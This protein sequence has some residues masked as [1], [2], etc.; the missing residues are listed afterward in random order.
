MAYINSLLTVKEIESQTNSLLQGVP[1]ALLRTFGKGLHLSGLKNAVSYSD[2]IRDS[3]KRNLES[4]KLYE[5]IERCAGVFIMYDVDRNGLVD[6]KELK[7]MLND[8]YGCAIEQDKID[9]WERCTTFMHSTC[10]TLTEFLRGVEYLNP[11]SNAL[12]NR[13]PEANSSSSILKRL[14]D[15]FLVL[16]IKREETK[17]VDFQSVPDV[18]PLENTIWN[19]PRCDLLIAHVRQYLGALRDARKNGTDGMKP[20][21]RLHALPLAK[22]LVASKSAPQLNPPHSQ[23]VQ[24]IKLLRSIENDKEVSYFLFMSIYAW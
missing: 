13:E 7:W 4:E 16:N 22:S 5:N 23:K 21:N 17:T 11:G 12:N 6:R 8:Y 14:S 1:D 19:G 15:S 3:N 10:I 9:T 20:I 2:L 24:T 18:P